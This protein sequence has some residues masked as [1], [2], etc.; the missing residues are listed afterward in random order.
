MIPILYATITEGTV[1]TDY[2]IGALTDCLSC[3]VT[4]ERNGA[5]EL[6]L[7]YSANGIHADEILPNRFILAKPNFNDSPQLFQIYK[8]GK[9]MDGHFVVNAQ[10]AS[11]LLSGKVITEGT[12]ENISDACALL[13]GSAGNFTITTDKAVTADFEITE[14]SSVRSWFGGKEGSLPDVYGTGE[15]HFNNFTCIFYL[16]RGQNRGVE[17]RYAKNLTELSQEIDVQS[18]CTGI[19]PFYQNKENELLVVGDKVPTGLVS[20]IQKDVAIDFTSDCNSESDVPI[21][22]QL[23]ILA[24]RYLSRN[25]LNRATSS[26][27]LDFV[28]LSSLEE[29]VDLCDTVKIV[30]EPLGISA[31]MKCIATTWDV[32]EGRYTSTTFGDPKTDITD[33]I[34]SQQDALFQNS[35]EMETMNQSI[36]DNEVRFYDFTNLEQIAFGSDYE[37]TLA[38]I[39]F[40]ATA[41]TTVKIMHEFIFDIL[42][43][44]SKD[45][46]YT[47]KYYLD[48]EQIP[49]TPFERIG[50]IA[51]LTEGD[52]TNVSITRDFFYILRDVTPNIRHEW[53]VTMTAHN[54]GGVTIG[55]KNGHVVLEGQ[56]LFASEHFDG[57]IVV[58]DTM[59]LFDFGYISPVAMEESVSFNQDNDYL[60]TESGDNLCAENGDKIML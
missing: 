15:W 21:I 55:I 57:Y 49:Y 44:L 13:Q 48:G 34:A 8:V 42:E 36:V 7:E 5:Y 12:A 38:E 28:Q 10:H 50:A 33:T 24:E 22:E 29:R 4:E 52:S 43:D 6:T 46:Y 53:K 35:S 25:I 56:K 60:L 19:I 51:Q 16:H 58:E 41:T 26:I 20:L 37:A 9:S 32:L 1:P 18:L 31:E 2:G 14:P 23:Q 3:E 47:I 39:Q 40:T 54:V 30:F 59:E 27:T 11:Y 17:L 45:N